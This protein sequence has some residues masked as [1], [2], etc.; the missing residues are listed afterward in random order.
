MTVADQPPIVVESHDSYSEVVLNR[1]GRRNAVTGPLVAELRQA[2]AN[3]ARTSDRVILLRGEG[4]AFCSGLDLK[5]FDAEPP[6][7]WVAEFS[8]EWAA[9]HRDLYTYPGLVVCALERF[10]INAGAA[11]ALACDFVVAGEQ[12]FLHVGEAKMARPAPINLAWL[13]LR[14][15]RRAIT[16]VAIRAARVPGPDLLR[17]GLAHRVVPDDGVLGAARALAAEL[18]ELPGP[19][20]A[21]MKRTLGAL[22]QAPGLGDPFTLAGAAARP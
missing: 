9:L 22:E 2:L 1:P 4:G 5:E 6:P 13:F 14:G 19:T 17:L 21:A 16:E 3:A 20:I 10:A 11:L 15:G 8:T 7:A 12:S 18:A